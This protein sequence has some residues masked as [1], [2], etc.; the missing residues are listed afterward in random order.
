MK[1]VRDGVKWREIGHNRL[2]SAVSWGHVFVWQHWKHLHS[3]LCLA[4]SRLYIKTWRNFVPSH[5]F[6]F[7]YTVL[8]RVALKKK[9]NLL[10]RENA[11]KEKWKFR[12]WFTINELWNRIGRYSGVKMAI[13]KKMNSKKQY[14]LVYLKVFC[15]TASFMLLMLS[16]PRQ[17]QL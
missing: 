10:F 4:T 8:I 16:K 11:I 9:F 12:S 5:R 7:S 1:T 6:F 2:N 3:F 14:K 13:G 17:H 15:C